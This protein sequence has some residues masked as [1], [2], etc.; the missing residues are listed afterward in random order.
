MT[1]NHC[2]EPVVVDDLM[3]AQDLE[4]HYAALAVRRFAT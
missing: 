2:R 4:N 1:L 3:S